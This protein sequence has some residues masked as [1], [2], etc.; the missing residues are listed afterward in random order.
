MHQVKMPP[1]AAWCFK[2]ADMTDDGRPAL[3]LCP[4]DD[5]TID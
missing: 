2:V 3:R 4:W 1:F 5:L